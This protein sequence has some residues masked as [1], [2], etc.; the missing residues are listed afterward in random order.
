MN[1]AKN[2]VHSFSQLFFPHTCAGCGNDLITNNQFLCL[3]CIDQLPFTGFELHADNPV[4]KNFWG[5]VSIYHATSLLYFTKD[6]ILQNL[7]HQFKYRGKKEIG[8]YFGKMMGNAILQSGRFQDIDALVPLPLFAS[9]EKR[10]GYNQSTILCEGMAE[11]MQV[12][13]LKNAVARTT[14]TETQT[15]KDRIERWQNIKGKFELKDPQSLQNKHVFLV[16]DVVTTGAT[17]E[18]CV[19]E[20]LQAKNIKVSIA[21][22]AYTSM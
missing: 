3:H 13:V 5:R 15:H 19:S 1:A 18:A 14:A 7:L 10:R 8:F 20:L 17:L 21:T 9:K 6:S 16:D 2:I 11:V 4:E 12:P 22:L